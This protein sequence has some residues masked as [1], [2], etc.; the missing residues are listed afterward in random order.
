MYGDIGKLLEKNGRLQC[1]CCG[2]FFVVLGKHIFAKH[3]LN[4]D[5]YREKFGLKRGAKLASEEN[6][7]LIG[8]TNAD[9]L[10]TVRDIN[11]L[12]R[13]SEERRKDTAGKKRRKQTLLLMQSHE[14][15]TD[16]PILNPEV[17]AKALKN[18]MTPESIE[19]RAAAHRGLKHTNQTKAKMSAAH[20]G[21]V[22]S[23]ATRKKLAEAA[24]GKRHADA[25]KAKISEARRKQNKFTEEI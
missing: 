8:E 23:K 16:N 7:Q 6:R 25:T 24:T 9:H 18:S 20:T 4:G 21:K 10:E 12:S 13:S 1:H 11:H 19:K 15:L 17:R 2:K 14:Y 5:E 22:F 3:N